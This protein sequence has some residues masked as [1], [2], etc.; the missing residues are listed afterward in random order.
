MVTGHS[1]STYLELKLGK[2]HANCVCPVD[3]AQR[4]R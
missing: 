1:Q 2:A 3:K 4:G